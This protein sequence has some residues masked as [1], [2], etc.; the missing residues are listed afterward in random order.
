MPPL[1]VRGLGEDGHVDGE[2]PGRRFHRTRVF[3]QLP[4]NHG[5]SPLHLFPRFAVATEDLVTRLQQNLAD[6][7]HAPRER[8][9]QRAPE[10][11]LGRSISRLRV[12]ADPRGVLLFALRIPRLPHEGDTLQEPTVTRVDRRAQ[13]GVVD[14]RDRVVRP[15]RTQLD[16]HRLELICCGEHLLGLVQRLLARGQTPQP[17]ALPAFRRPKQVTAARLLADGRCPLLQVGRDLQ[18]HVLNDRQ[19]FIERRR[20]PHRSA[21]SALLRVDPLLPVRHCPHLGH[22][23]GQLAPQPILR[24]P[25]RLGGLPLLDPLAASALDTAAQ[26]NPSS[27]SSRMPRIVA[28]SS[29][30]ARAAVTIGLASAVSRLSACNPSSDRSRA[31]PYTVG[32]STSTFLASSSASVALFHPVLRRPRHRR[33]S[34]PGLLRLRFVAKAPD[35]RVGEPDRQRL[36]RESLPLLGETLQ[37]SPVRPRSVS[38]RAGGRPR[39]RCRHRA[40]RPRQPPCA[41][42]APR[43]PGLPRPI[44]GRDGPD[45]RCG[46]CGRPRRRRVRPPAPPPGSSRGHSPS[47]RQAKS[48]CRARLPA[49]RRRVPRRCRRP[50]R[51]P[52]PRQRALAFPPRSGRAPRADVRPRLH[53][54]ARGRRVPWADRAAPGVRARSRT[55]S[56]R[57]AG[58]ADAAAGT[59]PSRGLRPPRR[60]RCAPDGCRP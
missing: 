27:A 7:P 10:V 13:Q 36:R 55:P 16:N 41:R 20:A 57:G 35:L 58:R 46:E 51:P 5:Q 26:R 39:R 22:Q 18:L 49:R 53:A 6:Y 2:P 54:R 25:R 21:P 1:G 14:N 31:C 32:G 30:A 50:G 8:I 23:G 59:P 24:L 34:R 33:R 56:V 42:G 3:L 11:V 44:Q 17:P 47:R 48:R 37:D 40:P 60:V 28:S 12:V 45:R 9:H 29:P 52:P 19:A 38:A 4:S 43:S 15:H